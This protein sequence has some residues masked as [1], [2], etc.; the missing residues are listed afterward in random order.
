MQYYFLDP[1][2]NE[3]E[4]VFNEKEFNRLQFIQNFMFGKTTQYVTENAIFGCDGRYTIDYLIKKVE[5][6]KK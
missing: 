3:F 2:N 4:E 6:F 5:E 1:R